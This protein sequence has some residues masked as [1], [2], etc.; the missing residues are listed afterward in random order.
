MRGG[1]HGATA[2]PTRRARRSLV[3]IQVALA[4]VVL[5][6]AGVLTRSLMRLQAVGAAL[7]ADRLMY[8]PLALPQETYAD[9]RRRLQFL[10]D[11]IERLESSPM[12]TAATPVNVEPFSGTGWDVPIFTAEGQSR[13][14]ADTNPSLNLEA[15][16]STYFETFEVAIV[17]GR[18]FTRDDR[19]GMPLVAIVSEDVANRTW[20]GED[21]IGKRLKMGDF[22]SKDLWRTVVGVAVPTRYRELRDRRA[23]L[24]VPA[25]QLMV[26]AETLVLRTASSPAAIAPLVAERLHAIDPGVRVLRVATFDELLERPLARPRFNAILIGVFGI[27]AL[28]L[29]AVGVYA[30]MAA[31]VRLRERDIGIRVALGATASHVRRLVI[32]EGSRLAG[33][34]VALGLGAALMA[35]QLLRGLLFEIDPLDPVAI[36][37]GAV[38]LLT[39]AAV[40]CYLPARRATRTDPIAML[41]SD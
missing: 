27:A 18:P 7:A 29:A 23:T 40:A 37:A 1:G 20:P 35:N 17:R 12:I 13:S 39:A 21:P 11:A 4:V 36:V 14:N 9:P 30:V 3:V 38:F 31:Y 8:V 6:A 25:E 15:I 41:R 2:Q 34:G 5:A 19:E 24:Y 28:F 22:E 16:H 10:N 33:I 32:G 26:T